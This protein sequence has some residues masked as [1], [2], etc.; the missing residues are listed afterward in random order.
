[1]T[2]KSNG[3][4][5]HPNR[6]GDGRWEDGYFAAIRH[7]DETEEYEPGAFEPDEPF[8]RRPHIV[9]ETARSSP[10]RRR[11]PAQTSDSDLATAFADAHCACVRYDATAERWSL[12]DGVIWRLDQ[13]D[14][15]PALMLDIMSQ[16]GIGSAKNCGTQCGSRSW[17]HA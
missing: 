15:V 7:P 3:H 5:G 12:F 11:S 6:H 4:N 13:T 1:M 17:T 9:A 10:K 16:H 14:R 8:E 2:S